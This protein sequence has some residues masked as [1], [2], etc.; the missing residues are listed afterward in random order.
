MKLS[1]KNIGL[2][3][4]VLVVL[5]GAYW[6]LFASSTDGTDIPLYA[7]NA[8]SPAESRFLQL[9]NELK[10]I[11][12]NTSI[13]TDERFLS[14]IDISATVTAEAM[15]REDPFVPTAKSSTEAQ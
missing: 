8:M 14:L 6:Y 3:I 5:G 7:V 10:P 2:G 13:L 4:A 11:R 9:G 12:F 1:S 15:G